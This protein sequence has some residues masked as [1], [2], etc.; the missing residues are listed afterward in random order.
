MDYSQVY[1]LLGSPQAA[2]AVKH[3]IES[4]GE[5]QKYRQ[6]FTVSFSNPSVNLYKTLPKDGNARAGQQNRT[7]STPVSNSS[8]ISNNTSQSGFT[9]NFRGGRGGGYNNRGGAGGF[10]RGGYQQQIS[11]GGGGFQ[12]GGYSNQTMGAQ[13]YN[14]F[15]GRGGMMGGMRGGMNMRGRGGMSQNMMGN[16]GNLGVMPNMMGMPNMAGM[17]MQGEL[18]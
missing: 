11:G 6:K 14:N 7:P 4:F 15:N 13:G 3:K 16:W 17:T 12:S 10:N 18:C 8:F 9:G 5:G 2:T 1:L